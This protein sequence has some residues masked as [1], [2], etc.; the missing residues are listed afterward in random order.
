MRLGTTVQHPPQLIDALRE[1]WRLAADTGASVALALIESVHPDPQVLV[2]L[3]WVL[4]RSCDALLRTGHR[5]YAVIFPHTEFKG[6]KRVMD[7]FRMVLAALEPR[8]LAKPPSVAVGLA[9]FPAAGDHS[10]YLLVDDAHDAL[11]HDKA[12]P[13]PP[14]FV[15]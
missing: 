2:A 11:M 10:L 1:E 13:A 15:K 9:A 12:P 5:S 4:S 3:H 14:K 6:A 8:D 7:R